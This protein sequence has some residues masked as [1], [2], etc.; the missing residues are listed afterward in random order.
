MVSRLISITENIRNPEKHVIFFHGL[1]GHPLD[2]WKSQ[3]HEEG[4]LNWLNE[5]KCLCVWTVDYEA[6]VSRWSGRTGM[7]YTDRA[8]NILKLVV[9]DP[10]LSSGKIT[11]IGHSLGGLVIKQILRNADS[12]A[13]SDS[14]VRLFLNRVSKVG[15]LG[16]PHAGADTAT[17]ADKLRIFIRPSVAT[18][19]LVRNDPSLRDL[20]YWYREW[21]S[22][23]QITN[24][25]LVESK[26]I[27]ILGVIVK[28]DSSDPGLGTRPISVDEDHI[29]LCKPLSKGSEVYKLMHDFV[30]SESEKDEASFDA[31]SHGIKS[32]KEDV[33]GLKSIIKEDAEKITDIFNERISSLESQSEQNIYPTSLVDNEILENI[34][35][36]RKARFFKEFSSQENAVQ[37]SDRIISGDLSGATKSQRC[38]ALGWCARFLAYSE[39]KERAKEILRIARKIGSDEILE[40]ASAFI[41]SADDDLQASLQKLNSLQTPVSKTARMMCVAHHNEQVDFFK[42]MESSGIKFDELD[43]DGK[44]FYLQKILHNKEWEYAYRLVNENL[45][46]TD[47]SNCPILYHIAALTNLSQALPVEIRQHV[48]SHPPFQIDFFRLNASETALG[49]RR[50]AK[51]LFLKTASEANSLECKIAA[52]IASDYALWLELEDPR[53]KHIGVQKLKESM[54]DSEQS[55]RRLHFALQLGL[56]VD[57]GAVEKEIDRQT[58]LSAG[59]SID[60]AISRFSLI[61]TK[62]PDEVVGYINAHRE[63]LEGALGKHSIAPIEVAALARAGNIEKARF[64]LADVEKDLLPENEVK[65]LERNI[66]E[67]EG[68]VDSLKDR[69]STFESSDELGDLVILANYLEST[70]DWERLEKFGAVLLKRTGALSDAVLYSKAL[71]KLG[72]YGTLVNLYDQHYDLVDQ[73]E[74]L[75]SMWAW[76]L[77]YEGRV[78]DSQKLVNMLKSKRDHANDRGLLVNLAIVSGQ[79]DLLL[80]FLEQEW[81]EKDNRDAAELMQ[82]ANLSGQVGS[83]RTKDFVYEAVEKKNNDPHILI[84]AY[85][86]ATK[87]GW[88]NKAEVS[89]WLQSSI[90]SSDANGPVQQF[91]L[92]DIFDKKQDWDRRENE[93]WSQYSRGEIPIS[94]AAYLLNRSLV[95][96][97]LYTALSNLTLPDP[98]TRG[99][100]PA[101]SGVRQYLKSDFKSIAVDSTALLTLAFLGLLEKL[102]HT[103]DIVVIPHSTLFW[104]FN[105]REKNNFHQPSR[106]NEAR[107]TLRLLADGTLAELPIN[108]SPDFDLADEVGEELAS[109]IVEAQR[110]KLSGQQCYVIR[111]S[112]VHKVQ[113]LMEEE[114][115]LIDH[116]EVLCSCQSLIPKLKA[117]GALTVRE[118]NEALSYLTFHEKPWDNQPVIS[119]G[120][121]LLLDNLSVNYL[122]YVGVLEKL[123]VAGFKLFITKRYIEGEQSLL[124]YEKL[125][126][127][128]DELIETV[129]NYLS[130]GIQKGDVLVG[131]VSKADIPGQD[132]FSHQPSFTV[133]E[134]AGSVDAIVADDRF[135]NKHKQ[136]DYGGGYTKILTVLDVINALRDIDD[137][138]QVEVY[139]LNTKLRQAGYTFV[140][141]TLEEV[142]FYLATTEI[143]NGM[144]VET[145]ELKAVRESLLRVKMTDYLQLPAEAPWL[146]ETLK[147]LLQCIRE[148]WKPGIDADLSGARS[149]WLLELIDMRG[150]SHCLGGEKGIGMIKYGYAS[151]HMS[152]AFAPE[153]CN[154]SLESYWDWV[155]NR[156]LSTLREEDP[157]LFEWVLERAKELITETLT[158]GLEERGNNE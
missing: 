25:V 149:D 55:L 131:K 132:Q 108:H 1:G 158:R 81:V 139:E 155:E 43:S 140:P 97:T 39:Q 37:L 117:K 60:A 73:S 14:R 156:L 38:L 109:L 69:I 45:L 134:L 49:Y 35:R 79:W 135:F 103:V 5:E 89:K 76:A 110:R 101:F 142:A 144:V 59:K 133:F 44:Y 54:R 94:G 11:L 99:L 137:I 113:S 125:L 98:R 127:R 52:N 90:Q 12:L 115:D 66:A 61:F 123:K 15:F 87:L 100:V 20:N 7:H 154:D 41:F 93:T 111:S 126:G 153:N 151:Q 21:V 105:E 23:R 46:E 31:L 146:H 152:L 85:S 95:D 16:T 83:P 26:P 71:Y 112:P 92:K 57:L 64:L 86:L 128:V 47:Y 107:N 9:S 88:E 124:H 67:C 29:S 84:A 75:S 129:R 42:W 136:I 56:S 28:P 36:I 118:E 13:N 30:M 157:V 33:S 50:Q 65:I 116:H 147:S 63:Q 2:T 74:D 32:L 22:G 145:A 130:I 77:Y 62:T 82:L 120:A 122:R 141:L 114:A 19:S 121:I 48:I 17:I 70:S 104:L 10:D 6:P 58:A 18:K 138:S 72:K 148:Q 27:K 106:I 4:M 40:I 96:L 78:N 3:K 143:V 102:Q 24:L 150:W 119:D 8:T 80:S 34:A 91:S 53:D 51:E 68:T